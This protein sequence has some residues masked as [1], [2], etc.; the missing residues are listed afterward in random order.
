MIKQDEKWGNF[1]I[2]DPFSVKIERKRYV[3]YLEYS[4]EKQKKNASVRSD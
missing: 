4:I 2:L 1:I 3:K